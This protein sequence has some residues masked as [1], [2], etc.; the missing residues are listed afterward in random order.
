MSVDPKQR[1]SGIAA[2]LISSVQRVGAILKVKKIKA[3]TSSAQVAALAFYHRN[4][5]TEV[6]IMSN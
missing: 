3:E 2:A 6:S 1:K 5:W 4:D